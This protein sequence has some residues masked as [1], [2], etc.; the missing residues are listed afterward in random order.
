MGSSGK[1]Y[2]VSDFSC[3]D[4]VRLPWEVKTAAPRHGGSGNL[5][6]PLQKVKGDRS[7]VG[8]P[9]SKK[10]VTYAGYGVRI[11][12]DNG[13]RTGFSQVNEGPD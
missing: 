6:N 8:L 9:A 3:C 10:T 7:R 13:G 5:N 11:P 12:S 2:A 1:V 4:G